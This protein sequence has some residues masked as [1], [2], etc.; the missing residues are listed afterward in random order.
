MVYS[1]P[2]FNA[3]CVQMRIVN[4][5]NSKG[6]NYEWNG[7]AYQTK[8]DAF[9][10]VKNFYNGCFIRNESESTNKFLKYIYF[11]AC[12]NG[13]ENFTPISTRPPRGTARYAPSMSTNSPRTGS[14]EAISINETIKWQFP[15][16]V[17][18]Y[19]YVLTDEVKDAIKLIQENTC[20]KIDIVDYKIE[21]DYGI[22]II[23]DFPCRSDRIGRNPN[24]KPNIIQLN[25]RCWYDTVKI[26][27]FILEALGLYPEQTRT[28]RDK[29]VG[30]DL[31]EV[32]FEYKYFFNINS[33]KNTSFYNTNY[34]YGSVMHYYSKAFSKH[35]VLDTIIPI[36]EHQN[37]YIKMIGQSR[38]VG[39][40]D[41]RLVNLYYC[42]NKCKK[43]TTVCWRN[44]YP[45]PNN[46]SLCLCPYPFQGKKCQNWAANFNYC[47]IRHVT[48]VPAGSIIEFSGY[49]ACYGYI[50]AKRNKRIKIVI[51]KSNLDKSY[52]C[53]TSVNSIEIKYKK[54]LSLMGV[55]F[56]EPV[57]NYEVISE[58][59]YSLLIYRGYY[60]YNEVRVRY[61][62][63]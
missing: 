5:N 36:S 57:Y 6:E 2:T 32:K 38:M 20:V 59:N 1:N 54:D 30:I 23:Y 39:F 8:E 9:N 51:E 37:Y 3:P 47:P 33:N 21:N 41:Y 15:I 42:N 44:G 29:Y 14:Y 25:R 4:H 28:D 12:K 34:D 17:N 31:C 40:N 26:Q 27:A 61:Y 46:C 35:E 18:I 48:A 19:W 22:N 52:P 60:Y 7:Y 62:E 49:S 56:C 11:F 58:T 13:T 55:C 24:K 63:V 16:K 53:A 45:N 43:P 10:A 50:E